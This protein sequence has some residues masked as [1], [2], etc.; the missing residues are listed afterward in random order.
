MSAREQYLHERRL[1][2]E[3]PLGLLRRPSLAERCWAALT[4]GPAGLTRAEA[5]LL[6]LALAL[7][8]FGL[9]SLPGLLALYRDLTASLAPLSR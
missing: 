4:G 8:A 5:L 7:V 3:R 2:A 6:V 1:A 9:T